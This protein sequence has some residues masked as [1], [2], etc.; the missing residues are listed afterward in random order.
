MIFQDP[1][2]ALNPVHTVGRQIAEMVAGAPTASARS[3]RGR[4]RSRCSTWSASRSRNSGR[5]MHPHEFSGGMRQRA[6]I[7][8]AIACNPDLLIADEPTTALDVTV[9]AQVLEVLMDIKDAHRLGDHA[10]HP[11]PRRRRRTRRQRDGDVRRPAGRERRRRRGLLRDPRTRTRSGCWRRCRASTTAGTRSSSRSAAP[12]PSLDQP[13]AGVRLPPAVRL[14]RRTPVA[15]TVPPLVDVGGGH[16]SACRRY[17]SRRRST[18]TTPT[19]WPGR[20]GEPDPVTALAETGPLSR[21]AALGRAT[22]S[23]SSRSAV[24]VLGRA[25]AYVQAVSG[26][27][28]TWRRRRR[29]AWWGSPAAASRPPADCCSADRAHVRRRCSSRAATSRSAQGARSCARCAQRFQIVFQDPYASL[30]PRMHGRGGDRRAAARA[31]RHGQ[32]RGRR[33]RRVSC[34]GWSD[35]TPEHAAALPA[36]VLRRPAPARRASPARWLSIRR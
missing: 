5:Q 15:P 7:A 34:C 22:S 19:P 27:S 9:Q 33:S 14:R 8:M 26:V 16:L 13:A 17:E 18:S 35:C 30:N 4:G 12:P 21:P 6:M 23:S 11:R 36:R 1:L 2:T 24:G 25:V 28:S 10:D 3:R 20:D 29:S 32:G 31:S